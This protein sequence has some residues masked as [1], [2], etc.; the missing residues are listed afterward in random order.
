MDEKKYLI[1]NLERDMWWK[2][3]EHG[4]TSNIKKAGLYCES[5]AIRIT[6]DANRI[7]DEDLM[8]LAN[9]FII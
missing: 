5:D 8:C 3:L 2:P 9:D 4:Y 6:R 7:K 1:W